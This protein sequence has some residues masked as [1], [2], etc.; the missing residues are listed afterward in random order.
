MRKKEL[1]KNVINPF[2]DDFL[3]HWDLWKQYKM[4]EFK[5]KYKGVI[6]EQATL[7]Q[8]SVISGSDEQVAVQIIQQSMSNGWKGL[9][10]IKNNNNNGT[11][12]GTDLQQSVN[13]EFAARN[14]E[15]RQL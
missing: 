2:S 7:M 10:P 6:S 1:P 13:Q 11:K 3:E 9:F 15:N 8:L 5:F 4:E 14:Y 12:R